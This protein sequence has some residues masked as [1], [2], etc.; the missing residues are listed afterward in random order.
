MIYSDRLSFVPSL[1]KL[2]FD[3]LV[4]VKHVQDLHILILDGVD[5]HV[6]PMQAAQSGR[7]SSESSPCRDTG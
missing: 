2:P 3:V 1:P 4:A 5:N 6:L 7:K